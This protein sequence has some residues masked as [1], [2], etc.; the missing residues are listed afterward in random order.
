MTAS[1]YCYDI[2]IIPPYL[3]KNAL[4]CPMRFRKYGDNTNELLNVG[5][6]R[7]IYA[8]SM[9]TISLELMLPGY[10]SSVFYFNRKDEVIYNLK[11][12]NSA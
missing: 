6:G 7:P 2:S 4:P 5:E 3:F 9:S 8:T 1:N 11:I 10:V 12:E